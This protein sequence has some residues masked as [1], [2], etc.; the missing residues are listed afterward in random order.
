M[1]APVL[2]SNQAILLRK[3]QFIGGFVPTII[4]MLSSLQ[5]DSSTQHGTLS[6]ISSSCSSLEHGFHRSDRFGNPLSF[7]ADV[8]LVLISGLG[9][10][11]GSGRSISSENETLCRIPGVGVFLRPVEDV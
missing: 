10:V 7:L 11:S 3:D 6:L 1:V 9:A 4:P 2:V 8:G 5:P